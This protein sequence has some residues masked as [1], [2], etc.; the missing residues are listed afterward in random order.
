MFALDIED[1]WPPV[2]SEGVWCERVDKNYRMKNS[3]FS[4]PGIA[5]NDIF[6]AEIDSVN[7]HIFGFEIIKESGHSVVW[8]MNNNDL[9]ISEFR[10]KIIDLGCSFEG[11]PKFSLGSIDIPHTVDGESFE[12]LVD[13][14]E[15][16]GIDFAFP[17]WRH[18]A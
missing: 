5:F 4:I 18:G 7:E 13:E 12:R 6:A 16:K 14:Y 10:K 9:D 17:V 3:P 8:L 11:F 1:G 15:E 2:G